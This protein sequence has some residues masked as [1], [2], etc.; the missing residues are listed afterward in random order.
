[1]NLHQSTLSQDYCVHFK[2]AKTRFHEGTIF[3]GLA[4]ESFET[5]LSKYKSF[6]DFMVTLYFALS[7][8][9]DNTAQKIRDRGFDDSHAREWT[10]DS[11]VKAVSKHDVALFQY[12]K[13]IIA[14]R[15]RDK[16]IQSKNRFRLESENESLI[17]ARNLSKQQAQPDKLA[18]IRD[19]SFRKLN[20]HS[21]KEIQT[22]IDSV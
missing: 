18:Q 6:D 14:T 21:D 16:L 5:E 4:P 8:D 9:G 2:N 20:S 10:W 3:F 19:E 7:E 17:A 15:G 12:A 22:I 1:M 13:R 11:V